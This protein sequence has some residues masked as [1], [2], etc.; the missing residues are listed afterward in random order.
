MSKPER[1]VAGERRAIRPD[2]LLADQRDETPG[3]FGAQRLRHEHGH[4]A[5]VEDLPLHGGTVDDGAFLA[6]EPVEAPPAAPGSS[7]HD[8]VARCR[9]RRRAQHLLDEEGLPSAAAAM[10][11]RVSGASSL[12]SRR[13]SMSS[14]ASS[15]D[16]G[17][18][19]SVT[20]FSL[21]PPQPG[22]S[23]SKSGLA[24]QTSRMRRVTREV[25]DVVDEVEERRLGP[26][27]VVEH[28][29]ERLRLREVL[30]QLPRGPRDLVRT[31]AG[32]HGAG[33]PLRDRLRVRWPRPGRQPG[34][35]RRL[36][37]C[38]GACRRAGD[39]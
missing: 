37:G 25:G 26:V 35:E 19:S 2:Q 3:H 4:G 11:A 1:L 18:S 24:R 17:S 30:E 21:P 38:L 20:A 36:R 6:A 12:P 33:E 29:H 10:R 5:L 8:E 23:S 9:P 39:R 28:D 32:G 13:S 34:R 15:S 22:R 7:P 16:S 31:R 14:L 27:Q